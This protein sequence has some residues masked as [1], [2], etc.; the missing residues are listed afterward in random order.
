M[1]KKA[2][3]LAAHLTLS[4]VVFIDLVNKIDEFNVENGSY[5]HID[6]EKKYSYD[7]FFAEDNLIFFNDP[8]INDLE[9]AYEPL[10]VDRAALREFRYALREVLGT[11]KVPDL[12]GPTRNETACWTSD[13][14]SFKVEPD[15]PEIHRS[16]VRDNFFQKDENPYGKLTYDFRFRRS[17]IPVAPANFRDAWE[18]NFDTLYT[19]RSISYVMRRIVQPIPYSAMYDSTIAY[20]RKKQ[21]LNK[22]SSL[23]LMTDFRKSGITI[24]RILITTMGEELSKLYPDIEE[25]KYIAGYQALSLFANG[26][27]QTPCRGTGLGNMNELYTLLQCT[28]GHLSKKAFGTGSIFFNDDAVYELTKTSYRRHVVYIISFLKKL[29]LIL[30]LTKSLISRGNIFCEEYNVPYGF[31]FR[32]IQLHIL[33]MAGA[34]FTPNTAIAKRYLYSIERGLIGTGLRHLACEFQNILTQFYKNEFGRMDSYL[35]YHLGGW[36]DF[37]SSN[38]SC[39]AEF[40]VDPG[41]YLTTVQECGSIPEI[42]RWIAFNIGKSKNSDSSILSSKAR[43]RYRGAELD[44]YVISHEVMREEDGLTDYI[45]NYIGLNSPSDT[46]DSLRDIINYRGLHNAKPKIKA[47]LAQRFLSNRKRIFREYRESK[48]G[49][50]SFSRDRLTLNIVLRSIKGMVDSPAYL[51]LPRFLLKDSI[52]TP[53]GQTSKMVVYKKSEYMGK[54]LLDIKGTIAS[55]IESIRSG[56]WYYRSDPFIFYDFWVRK[57]SGYLLSEKPIPKLLRA[58]YALP[59]DFRVYCP[60]ATLCLREFAARTGR[61]P[62]SWYEDSDLNQD[63]S[64]YMFKD[65][66]ELILPVDLIGKWRNVKSLYQ[67]DL[68]VLR[69]IMQGYNLITRKDFSVF[70]SCAEE[71]ILGFTGNLHHEVE[72]YDEDVLEMLERFE[73]TQVYTAIISSTYNVEDLLDDEEIFLTRDSDKSSSDN[74]EYEDF[75]EFLDSDVESEVSDLDLNEIR[76]LNREVQHPGLTSSM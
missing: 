39:L 45:Y 70:L 7:D 9:W 11:W 31:D 43:I 33:P 26:S 41:A 56:R 42:K 5:I 66:F 51:C 61:T 6:Q 75:E 24:P 58:N 49:L 76:R 36:I 73:D 60:N 52:Q 38:F 50:L 27:W 48:N 14:T 15:R 47:G 23:Y 55:T 54:P 18:P 25:F 29:G 8:D 16:I 1:L 57:K 21:L 3:A 63:Y 64:M 46:E 67:R 4:E 40:M 28:I 69:N 72:T 2:R 30:N 22:S 44:N 35:P 62:L 53:E 71:F 19:I 74:F 17:I 65:I 34:L 13:S 10:S 68:H 59:K 32:K 20:R 37:S 12:K